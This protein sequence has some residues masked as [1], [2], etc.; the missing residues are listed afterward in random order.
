MNPNASQAQPYDFK[1]QHTD[2]I[3]RKSSSMVD[4]ISNR[5]VVTPGHIVF[6]FLPEGIDEGESLSFEQLDTMSR[7]VASCLQQHGK[8]G[9]RVVLFF[10]PGIPYI[11][12][13]FA[14]FYAGMVAVPAYPPRRNRSSYR[15]FSIVE[16]AGVSMCLTS[17]QVK[18]DI[19]RNFASDFASQNL[20]W[21]CYEDAIM[22]SAGLWNDPNLKGEEL[23]LLQYTSGSTGE[24]KGV[25]ITHYQI[26]YNSEYIRQSFGFSKQTIGMNW[27][28][29]YHDMG[30][31]GTI[32]QAPYIGALSITM[33]P[34][35]FLQD[36]LKWLKAISRFKVTTA[37][38]PNFGFDH[39]LQKVPQH[40]LSHLDL[41]SVE[42][43]FCGAEPVRAKTMQDFASYFAQ[44]G[45]RPEQLYP[46]YGM[47]E[48]VLIVTG[49]NKLSPLRFITINSKALARGIV[50]KIGEDQPEAI[51]L[52]GCGHTWMD[53]KVR[54][55][56]PETY[57]A[58]PEGHT[59]E[60]W[61]CGS[62]VT[63]G[64]WGRTEENLR[65][66]GAQ[67]HNEGSTS[68][69]RSGDLGFMDGN[70]LY[71][72]G[73]IKD[74]LIFRGV[75]YYPTDIEFAVQ[76]A[77][78]S[79]RK[80]AGAAFSVMVHGEEQLIIAQEV[81]RSAMHNLPQ[82]ELFSTIRQ[83]LSEEF[84]LSVYAILLLRPGS[85]PLTSSGKIQRRV[86]KYGYLTGELQS[87]A[88]WKKETGNEEI[89]MT[90]ATITAE[91][92]QAWLVQWVNKKL[93]IPLSEIDVNKPVT[94]FGLDSLAAVAL[95]SEISAHFRYHWHIS[96]FMLDAT[97]K[98]MAVEGM[99]MYEQEMN[100]K[101]D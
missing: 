57:E 55:V 50:E 66:F 77:H 52:T 33:P 94:S 12:S 95:E 96:L 15:V 46:C 63:Q 28:P 73:R 7:S 30:L 3:I 13:L 31:I 90:A 25:M 68:Y 47:A 59:G 11:I 71:I 79:L 51:T 8:K 84:E 80:N 81:E 45:A 76:E 18:K 44:A 64:Y 93:H 39:C 27:L 99:A 98:Q 78:A 26:L 6:R 65:T 32:M 75:N 62:G 54:I 34:V 89:S 53:T 48:T 16:N 74:L 21:I 38:G 41:S 9:D 5:A 37:G 69:F 83:T 24:P 85:I 17:Q 20:H 60:I 70:E 86:T 82:D 61:I 42:T 56:H 14:C 97:I 67:I 100:S 72:T 35:A 29:I 10:Q 40:E 19:E 87:I 92:L 58:V 23:A 4:I 36:P 101:A 2:P 88:A 1:S 43:F 49:G 91:N 22:H